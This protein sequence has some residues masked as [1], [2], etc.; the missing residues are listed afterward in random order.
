MERDIAET[1]QAVALETRRH[2][3]ALVAEVGAAADPL[4]AERLMRGVGTVLA[5]LKTEVLEP[6]YA[7]HPDLR[8]REPS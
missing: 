3:D 4:T 6:V 8:E 7:E 2:L 5:A 1:I